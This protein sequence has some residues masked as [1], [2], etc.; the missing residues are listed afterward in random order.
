MNMPLILKT[1]C[2]SNFRKYR[3]RKKFRL[4]GVKI[5]KIK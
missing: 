3:S 2:I 5:V 1:N 4:G